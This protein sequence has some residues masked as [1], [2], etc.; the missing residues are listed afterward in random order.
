MCAVWGLVNTG[1]VSWTTVVQWTGQHAT[2]RETEL[3]FGALL[4]ATLRGSMSA[5]GLS[6]QGKLVE[7]THAIRGRSP[8]C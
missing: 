5:A 3:C 7:I 6:E 1:L 8:H 4:G 2:P